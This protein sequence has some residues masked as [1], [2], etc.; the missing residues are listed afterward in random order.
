[1][2]Q[3]I[4][5]TRLKVRRTIIPQRRLLWCESPLHDGMLSFVDLG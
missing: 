2:A 5:W 1:M 4:R 3:P